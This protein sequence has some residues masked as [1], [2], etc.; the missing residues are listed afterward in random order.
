MKA[1]SAAA[2]HE[3][4]PIAAPDCISAAMGG[5]SVAAKTGRDDLARCHGGSWG[6]WQQQRGGWGRGKCG[7]L[8]SGREGLGRV[9][10][11]LGRRGGRDSLS[12]RREDLT[13]ARRRMET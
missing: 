9:R 11:R 10:G 12:Q 7:S 4:N 13:R 5:R 6:L 3:E 2:T 8:S 1:R